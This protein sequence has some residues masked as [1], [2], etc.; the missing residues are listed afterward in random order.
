MSTV[1]GYGPDGPNR[2]LFAKL[3]APFAREEE[4]SR[5]QAGRT[6]NYVTARTVMN[7]LDEVLGA[8]NWWDDYQP[9]ENAIICRLTVR[10]PDGSTITKADAGGFTTTADTSD[11][12]KTGFSD[13]FKRVAVKFGVGRYLYGDGIPNSLR[14][15]LVAD[16]L[17]QPPREPGSDDGPTY[18]EPSRPE[19]RQQ[20]PSQPRRENGGGGN[21]S[22]RAPQ[23]GKAL[24]AWSK[25]QGDKT[26]RDVIAVVNDFGKLRGWPARMIQ[27]DEAQVAEAYTEASSFL[28]H[29]NGV[30]G[31][32]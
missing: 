24:F 10:L 22:G 27:W 23:S 16:R 6:F 15:T 13:A 18:A 8:D 26:G 28:A 12:E 21:Y 14:E 19:P 4:R 1:D 2:G 30:G 29:A 32:D 3:A 20:A 11:Y 17:A 31:H 7:R 9:M 5:T 25:D